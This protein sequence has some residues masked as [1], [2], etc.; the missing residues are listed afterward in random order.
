M[1][2][3]MDDLRFYVLVNSI[4]VISGR[5]LDDNERLYAMELLGYTSQI[6]NQSNYQTKQKLDS[7][8]VTP[9]FFF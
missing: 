6:R 5:C 7:L 9:T 2:G 3:W 8:T 1:D 4:L